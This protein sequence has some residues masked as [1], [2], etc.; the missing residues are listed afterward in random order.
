MAEQRIIVVSIFISCIV[1][2][3]HELIIIFMFEGI[4][5]M[6]MTLYTGKG[7][8]HRGL[9][10]SVDP[11]HNCRC[12]EFFIV[13]SAFIIGHSITMKSGGNVILICCRWQK[14]ACDLFN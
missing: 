5:R 7:G 10:S 12:S 11:V 4:V 2:E 14:I 6:G 1:E 9:P 8:T 3:S 13:S